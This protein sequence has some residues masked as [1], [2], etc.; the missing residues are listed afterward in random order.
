MVG[1]LILGLTAALS[2]AQGQALPD[3]P[4]TEAFI[5]SSFHLQETYNRVLCVALDGTCP[6]EI[7]AAVPCLTAACTPRDQ[8]YPV[9]AVFDSIQAAA[10][11][12]QPGDLVIIMP[13]RYAG[14]QFEETG[15]A[16][17]A[18]IHLLGWGEPGSVIVDRPARPDVN[19]LRHHFY[20]IDTHHIIIQ[21]LAFEGASRGAGLFFSGYFSGT[22][23]FSHH[24]IVLDVYSHDNGL[25]GLHS[26][27]ASTLLI[28][29]STFTNS[30]E[31]HGVY[32]SGSGDHIVIRRSVFQGNSAAGL[33]INADPQTATA[34][35]FYWL[36]GS[37]GETCGWSEDDVTFT[38]AATWPDLKACY[39]SQGLPDLGPYIEDGI[40]ENVIVEQNVITGNGAAGGA[41]INLASVRHAIIR[42]NLIYGNGAADIA[43]WDNAYA[44]EKG[45]GMSDYGCQDVRIIYNTLVDES[46]NRGAL[47]LNQDAQEMQVFN[48]IIV[49]DRYDAYEITGRSGQGLRS[50]GNYYSDQAVTDSPGIA[51]LDSDPASGSITGFSVAEALTAFVAPGFAP[52]VLEDGPWPALN[53]A[54]PDFHPHAESPLLAAVVAPDAPLFDLAG[55]PRSEGA[56]GALV[57]GGL[58]TAQTSSVTATNPAST[59]TGVITYT[60]PDGRLFR[61]PAQEGAAPEDVSAALDALAPGSDEWIN[62]SPDGRWLLLSTERFSPDCAGWACLA[63]LTADL[64]TVE[65]IR[66][67]GQVV[68]AQGF[69]A[70]ASVGDLIQYPLVV[71]AAGDGPHLLDLWAT[72]RDE[73][74]WSDP[75]L[76][77]GDSPYA[78]HSAPALAADGRHVLFDCG[79]EPYGAEGTA[80][81][82]AATDG[83]AFRT[84]LTPADSPPGLGESFALHQADYAPAN[85]IVFEGQWAG[86]QI[87]QLPASGQNLYRPSDAFGNDN[88]PCVLSDGR[89]VSLWLNREG[90]DPGYHEIKVMAADGA[91]FYMGLMGIDVADVGLGCGG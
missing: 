38:G 59:G 39:D 91:S 36:Q 25:W 21:N 18:Y 48:N 35:L 65:S 88:S 58:P 7:T 87:W 17:G 70:V 80:L 24:L 29:D 55:A 37:T 85:S 73:A 61:L 76:L 13:G 22:G 6:A 26:T 40:S 2:L 90:N 78:W 44:E 10:D 3:E 60:L 79:D 12:A 8:Q 23:R 31:E 53:P 72:V 14:L 89:I 9:T 82:E 28:Q 32:I 84:V 46:G 51:L 30:E 11:T 1:V 62:I 16:D 27:A 50:G 19:Y 68:H 45:L 81:C 33:Q 56:I 83:S 67:G 49:R 54:R 77:T 47:I 52:W 4:D 75:L 41:A 69:S 43:C 57:A 71:Y 5:N 63:I 34:E 15:G 74:G 20:L 86:E 42:N 66:A 64:E